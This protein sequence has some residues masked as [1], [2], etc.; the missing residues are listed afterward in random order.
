MVPRTLS[1]QHSL[2]ALTVALATGCAGAPQAGSVASVPAPSRTPP[3]IEPTPSSKS[4][5][6]SAPDAKPAASVPA[7]MPLKTVANALPP[8][9]APVV[10]AAAPVAPATPAEPAPFNIVGQVIRGEPLTARAVAYVD[11]NRCFDSIPSYRRVRSERNARDYARYLLLVAEANDEFRAAIEW[12][13]LRRG[14]DVV[15]TKGG[16]NDERAVDITDS[17]CDRLHEQQS[18]GLTR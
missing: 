1:I 9:A 13:V 12:V 15:V 4:D 6:A 2:I 8:T 18:S 7:A 14:L 5:V 10:S 16:V 17:V 3:T 11:V